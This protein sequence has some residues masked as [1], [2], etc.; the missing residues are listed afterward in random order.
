MDF[1]NFTFILILFVTA[2]LFFFVLFFAKKNR[3]STDIYYEKQNTLFTPAERSFLGVLTL[4]LEGNAL[5]FGK[6]RVADILKPG[7]GLSR[8]KWWS[9]FNK[10]SQK[11]FDFIVC[12]KNDLSILC[13]IELNDKSHESEKAQER[14]AF[15]QSA[16]LSARLPL[17]QIPAASSYSV[18]NIRDLL[19]NYLS[20][21]KY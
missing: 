2:I 15:L 6:I 5:V 11:H 4:A 3:S 14:D 21:K 8:K 7:G 1:T 10:I 13:A 12:E 20:D 19:I 9:L 16:C 18:E 17:I